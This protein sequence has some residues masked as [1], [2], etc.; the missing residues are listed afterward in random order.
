MREG[1]AGEAAARIGFTC[2][3]PNRGYQTVRAAA[4]LE[5]AKHDN[6][7]PAPADASTFYAPRSV[8]GTI[9]AWKPGHGSDQR[10]RIVLQV[11][12]VLSR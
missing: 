7:A 3:E 5:P 6:D 10:D 12:R 4:L 8:W 11:V 2:R 1:T 9:G